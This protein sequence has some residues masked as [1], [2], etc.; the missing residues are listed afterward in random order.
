MGKFAKQLL[1]KYAREAQITNIEANED[2]TVELSFSSE[3]P[4]ERWFGTEILCHDE[5]C[6]NL[7]R[8]NNGL[9]TLLFNHDR[10]AVVGHVDKVWIEDNRG[11]A[12]VRFDED[13]ESEKIYQKVLKGTLQGVSVGYDISRCEEL[14]DSDS[15][16]SN[17]RFTGPAYV[18]T[19]WEPLEISVVSVPADP[20]VGVGRSV[21]DNEEEPMKGDAKAKG[22]EQNVPQVVPEVPES[23][24]KGFNAD[25]AKKLIA[26]ERERVSTIT[27][28]C[29]DF[30]VDGVDEFIKSGKS[31]A[32]VREVVM[33]ALRERNKP[34]SVKVGEADSDKFRMAMQDALIMSV[35]IPVANPAPGANELRSMSLMELARESLVREG[36][37]ANYADRL[38]LAREAINSTSSFPIA[39]SNVANK[40]LMQGYET[41][42]STFA[43]WAGKGSNR[44]FKPAKRFLISEAAELKLV[45][46]GGQ[47]KDSQM[48]EAGTN[49]SVLTFG[50][51]F[52][53]TRQ[54]IINDDLGVFNDISSKFGRAAKSKI[55]NMVYDLLSGNTVLEDG[56]ALFSADRK[57][58]AT[59]GSELSIVSLAAGVAAMRRQKHIGENRNL[60]ISPTY[61]IVPP[62]LEALAYQVVKSVVDPARSNDTVNP[63]SGRFTIVVDAALTDPHA[64]YLASR[65]TDVQTIEVTYLNG[66]ETPRLETQTGFKVDGIEYRVAIDCNATAI[67]F[68]G[69]YKN[70]GK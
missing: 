34:V 41:A 56:K 69:L 61:L 43:I 13:D 23:G 1:G 39:L 52:S 38:E 65:P 48:S 2:R 55:N 30:E 31:V 15:K 50:R 51:T 5:G 17:G 24:V 58:L 40:A 7:D 4:Y 16:S 68:R 26:A 37:T 27:S 46:E 44:D 6:V 62:E 22:T 35:G 11:K 19:Y 20:S 14:I 32:E 9:G 42:P 12:I 18:I 36:L 60:N 45:P 33:D 67:D 49:V 3:E 10:S 47:F 59:A 28:L 53:L 54:A 57:N 21:D 29:R 8:F 66:V 70:P 63:F 25:D 64:W